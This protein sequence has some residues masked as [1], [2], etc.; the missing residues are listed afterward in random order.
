M[1]DR[2][3]AIEGSI[4]DGD[5]GE[6]EVELVGEEAVVDEEA[7]EEVV[8]GRRNG[9]LVGDGGELERNGRRLWCFFVALVNRRNDFVIGN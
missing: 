7:V 9:F 5:E 1:E 6:E 2:T 3:I 8:T 4:V